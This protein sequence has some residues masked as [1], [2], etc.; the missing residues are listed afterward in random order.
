MRQGRA[1]LLAAIPG[2]LGEFS[3]LTVT[4]MALGSRLGPRVGWGHGHTIWFGALTRVHLT[5]RPSPVDRGPNS[6]T[7]LW[8]VAS[9]AA[10]PLH[11][12]R[13]RYYEMDTLHGQALP[14]HTKILPQLLKLALHCTE[15]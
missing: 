3:V 12:T 9:D 2:A 13:S 6:T 8:L 1:S 10:Q 11:T 15:P 4:I 14:L 5:P 7:T